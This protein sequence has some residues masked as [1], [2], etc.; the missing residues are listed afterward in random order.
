VTRLRRT[1]V[2]AAILASVAFALL[3]AGLFP[4]EPLRRAAEARLSLATGGRARIGSLRVRPAR[5]SAELRDVSLETESWRFS[6]TRVAVAL[7]AS[8]LAGRAVHLTSLEIASP[9]LE[10]LAAPTQGPDRPAL[11][12]GFFRI[13]SL[14]LSEGEIVLAATPE[15]ARAVIRNV[16]AEG[17]LGHGSLRLEAASGVWERPE[18]V[19]AGPFA[20]TLNVSERLDVDVLSAETALLR[21]SRAGARGRLLRGGAFEPD[22][23]LEL[24]A[25]LSD[26]ERVGAKPPL[27]GTLT[28]SGRVHLEGE[29]LR[30][31]ARFEGRSL[32]LSGWPIDHALL[33]VTSRGEQVELAGGF[34]A[35]GGNGRLDGRLAGPNSRARLN[36]DRLDL[37]RVAQHLP[38]RAEA[39]TGTAGCEI[40]LEGD[41]DGEVGVRAE[42]GFAQLGSMRLGGRIE[43]SGAALLKQ[44]S[45]DVEWSARFDEARFTQAD[46]D[47]D[48]RLRRV[49][50]AGS[51]RG[52]FPPDIRGSMEG[53]VLAGRKGSAQE[54]A[55]AGSF[56]ARG[57][58]AK[59][60]LDGKGLGG[61]IAARLDA[62]GGN[63][64]DLSL[65]ASGLD[66][67]RFMPELRG[68]LAAQASAAGP[69]DRL[70]GKLDVAV[71]DASV[72]GVELG[73]A[74]LALSGDT[75]EAALSLRAPAIPLD[76]NGT[77]RLQKPEL[78]A[79]LVV[80]D[81]AVAR[82]RPLLPETSDVAGIVSASFAIHVPLDRPEQL[83]AR[84]EARRLEI[85]TGKLALRAERPIR[86][87]LERQA[88]TLRDVDVRGSGLFL[89]A[90]GHSGLAAGTPMDLR[91]SASADLAQL[92][93]PG[94]VKSSG[95]AQLELS[96]AGTREKPRASGE[97]RLT[98]VSVE[99]AGAPPL[100]LAGA[101]VLIDETTAVLE[102]TT[103][104][105][106][107]GTASVRGRVPVAAWLKT[108]RKNQDRLES[109]EAAHLELD[110]QGV[111]AATLAR[112]VADVDI[113]VAASL[114]GQL[115]LDGGLTS[116]DELRAVL[117]VP[118]T[119]AQIEELLVEV[120]PFE[121]RLANGRAQT[122]AISLTTEQ[123]TFTLAGFAD[124]KRETLDAS[125]R[126]DVELRALS[127]FLTEA[128][129]TGKAAID[130]AV[131]GTFAQPRA[132]GSLSVQDGSLRLRAFR[133]AV[134]DIDAA[135]AFEGDAFR[136]ERGAAVLGGGAIA[137]AGGGKLGRGGLRDVR[138]TIK[139]EN[140]AVRY[141]EGLR[142]R[143]DADLSLSGN[144]ESM[145]LAGSLTARRGLYDLDIAFEQGLRAPPPAP[146]SPFLRRVGVNL[147]VDIASPV[148][149]RN[150]QADLR[151]TGRLAFRG[152]LAE[153]VPFGRLEIQPGGKLY[154]EGQPF[155]I[156][157]GSLVYDGTWDPTVDLLA[158]QEIET[159]DDKERYL[160]RVSASGRLA[161]PALRFSSPTRATLSERQVMTLI[162]TRTLDVSTAET[163]TDADVARSGALLAGQQAATLLTGR[164]TRGV[165][166]RFRRLGLGS[167]T[168]EPELLSRELD[169]GARFAFRRELSRAISLIYSYSLTFPDRRFV[170]VDVR[171][172]RSVQLLTQRREDGS[173]TYGAGQ[174]FAVGRPTRDRTPAEE[175]LRTRL[176]E[177]RIEGDRPLSEKALRG[178]LRASPGKRVT[179]WDLQEGADRLRDRLSRE[180]Y[181]EAQVEMRLEGTVAVF[182]VRSGARYRSRVSGVGDP[183]DLGR[184]MKDV[185]HED[186]ALEK[187]REILLQALE[188]QGHVRAKVA[189][190][191]IDEGEWRTLQFDVTP[192]ARFGDVVVRFPG[193][194]H[195]GE[196]ELLQAAGGAQRLL[197]SPQEARDGIAALYRSH[198]FYAARVAAPQLSE[199]AGRIEISVPVE[200]GPPATIAA[201][202][203]EGE[204]LGEAELAG[205]AGVAQGRELEG[206]PIAEAV[207]R[208]QAEYMKRGYAG[209]RIRTEVAPSGS[210][211]ELIFHV[212]EGRRS[213]VGTITV[214]GLTRTRETLVR[215]QLPFKVGDPVD[216]RKLT[217]AER[218]LAD[219]GVFARVAVTASEE[220]ESV[221]TIAVEEDAR[222]TAAYDFRYNDEEH[223]RV[224][225]D[226]ELHNLF[227]WGLSLGGRQSVGRDIRES[228]VSLHLPKLS[229][230]G[231]L[232]LSG[233]RSKEDA[234]GERIESLQKG[235]ELQ[236]NVRFGRYTNL[237]LG[238]RF[239]RV[240][241]AGFTS[242]DVASL[243]L[244]LVR[245]T[246]DSPLDARRGR[247]L[248]FN[249]IVAPKRLGSD[250]DF[251]KAYAQA[252][253]HRGI[254]PSLTWSQGFRFGLAHVFGGETLLATERFRAGGA[255]SLR[256]FET[257]RV[258]PLNALGTPTGGQGVLVFNQELRYHHESG[259]GG[260]VF[261][262]AGN[263]F[264]RPGDL[265]L[266]LRHVLGIGARYAS[267]FGL[268]RI[269][270][271]FPLAR[272]PGEKTYRVYFSLGQAF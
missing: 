200:E 121:V 44:P 190:R 177:V 58:A 143:L 241:L 268:L 18:P 265:N 224:Q 153:P 260:V 254:A 79:E 78:T 34:Q 188:Q 128:A 176:S 174:R 166:E 2:F 126:G 257:D 172:G 104:T 101:T 239:K 244:S 198:D 203:F 202:R 50:A 163:V 131:K 111:P 168:V 217:E 132:A 106:A 165:S 74:T 56:E 160:V 220:P 70:R 145:Q 170:E 133:D 264:E 178:L 98:N 142:S 46:S 256:G 96:L 45:V 107:E 259:F 35:L 248:S 83:A 12:P 16:R 109:N 72:R 164:L 66:L 24:R 219:L 129:L 209:V 159:I 7:G 110:W 17:S 152:D 57:D 1:V 73:P 215:A 158:E 196:S 227:G 154:L 253:V 25:D 266:D 228:R 91:L 263:V 4:H 30:T 141:P 261:Y 270:L 122:E 187:G 232:T 33:Q 221:V 238:Y 81:A 150:N 179:S 29:T 53:T 234:R 14:K 214:T 130:V 139:G 115:R 262:D 23:Q 246:R 137:L 206:A 93:L 21:A 193:A 38:D 184:A 242:I 192:G 31:E 54:I 64:N 118:K 62:S 108:A 10:L 63:V 120:A 27:Q 65:K 173:F 3:L 80:T 223:E 211:V 189:A 87:D 43:A 252:F 181:L 84:G 125:A 231:S 15:R 186:E 94:D 272:R 138:L 99:A 161:Q 208:L 32:V 204:S 134:A 144:L 191:A 218:E 225:G 114:Q 102:P 201:I 85:Q 97:L 69:Y 243:D 205:I 89:K 26:L 6:A 175:D 47:V 22:L 88:L 116:F 236:Q 40:Q 39:L 245:D 117:S 76:G 48:V 8:T 230:A 61:T 42:V 67:G 180:G 207:A 37:R 240:D 95:S 237:L 86:I 36:V 127:A 155:E 226:L 171:P 119:T 123:G 82:L 68:R 151:A 41:P 52:A 28:G 103:L 135:V 19:S 146:P 55:V 255:N 59:L 49:A 182:R 13:D 167:V 11:A 185:L 140:M 249:T 9:R 75:R 149:V 112:Q 229:R 195:F 71:A 216:P 60:T 247:F 113:A 258:G 169:P 20:A 100:S 147:A 222:L 162:A 194:V 157:R 148:A 267:P 105:I 233:F 136:V 251:V 92:P 90:S 5:L 199:S 212:S 235:V 156:R 271:G 183:P 197:A 250:A 124:L 51:A 77:L 210:D 269:D 213:T